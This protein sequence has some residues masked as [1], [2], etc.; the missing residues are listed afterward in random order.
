MSNTTG[1]YTLAWTYPSSPVATYIS[2]GGNSTTLTLDWGTG[3]GTEIVKASNSCGE[4]SK[5]YLVNIGCKEAQ[6]VDAGTLSAY[7]NPTAGMLNIE[8][9]A[10]EK[11]NAS[12]S[13]IDLSGRTIM[14][15]SQTVTAGSNNLQLDLTN[16]AKGAYM[17][18][19]KAN[20][21]TQQIKVVVE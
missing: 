15:S 11:S 10:V 7:P 20:Q 19:V 1:S 3:N 4:G 16:V 21:F 2:G 6:Q 12:V 18:R 8:F 9:N 5:A 17:I 13:V 14:N